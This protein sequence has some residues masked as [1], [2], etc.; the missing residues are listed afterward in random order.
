MRYRP[1]HKLETHQKIVKDTSLRVRAE[2]LNGAAVAAG[3]ARH[4]PN[5]R[6]VLQR[7]FEQARVAH[8]YRVSPISAFRCVQSA[9]IADLFYLYTPH[10]VRPRDSIWGPMIHHIKA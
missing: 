2:G 7:L 5:S 8:C 1:E 10:F 4:R 9:L 3:N 6:R